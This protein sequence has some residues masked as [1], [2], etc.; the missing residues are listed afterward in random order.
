MAAGLELEQ[1]ADPCTD[2]EN[3]EE[4]RFVR[5][6][7]GGDEVFGDEFTTGERSR[8]DAGWFDDCDCNEATD[9]ANSDSGGDWQDLVKLEGV[10]Y[11]GCDAKGC[12]G[13]NADFFDAET[14]N[15]EDKA[16]GDR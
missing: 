1:D 12:D 9:G 8:D 6:G 3:N 4:P 10:D 11:C 16:G 15:A 5:D 14:E 13:K 7:C 2:G